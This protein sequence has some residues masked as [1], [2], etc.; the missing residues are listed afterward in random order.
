LFE[1]GERVVL[2][3]VRQGD[4]EPA[5]LLRDGMLRLSYVPGGHQS[6]PFHDEPAA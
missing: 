6:N 5:Q 4:L 1:G 3:R 2:E